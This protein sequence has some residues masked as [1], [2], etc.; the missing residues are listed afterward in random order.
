[1]TNTSP[2]FEEE[3]PMRLLAIAAATLLAAGFAAAPASAN[4]YPPAGWHGNNHGWHG[5]RHKVC[6]TV[7]RHHHRVRRCSWR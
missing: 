4:G 1:M 5:H 3:S 6:R 7:W 2:M